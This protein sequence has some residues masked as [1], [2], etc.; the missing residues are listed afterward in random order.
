MPEHAFRTNSDGVNSSVERGSW[1]SWFN[2][3][4][5]NNGASVA[6]GTDH[7]ARD[8]DWRGGAIVRREHEGIVD[9]VCH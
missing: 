5:R 1:R 6:E 8:D 9:E 2:E 7:V 4:R 3:R